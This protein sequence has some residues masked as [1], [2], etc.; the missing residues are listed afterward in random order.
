MPAEPLLLPQLGL[1]AAPDPRHLPEDRRG[2]Q[3]GVAQ[4][5]SWSCQSEAGGKLQR[6]NDDHHTRCWTGLCVKLSSNLTNNHTNNLLV[7]LNSGIFLSGGNGDGFVQVPLSAP[8]N[9]WARVPRRGSTSRHDVSQPRATGL[10][11]QFCPPAL[12]SVLL[13]RPGGGSWG[14]HIVEAGNPTQSTD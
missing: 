11:D 10:L 12:Q 7:C 14:Q 8:D 3:R 9:A 2:Q 5:P 6:T 1:V 13:C 4:H